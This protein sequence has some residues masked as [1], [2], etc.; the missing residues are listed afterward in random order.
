[1]HLAR[2][3][4]QQQRVQA[5]D[6]QALDVVRIAVLERLPDGVRQA[7]HR[8]AARPVEAGQ[9]LVRLQRVEAQVAGHAQ[10]V[11]AAHVFAPAQ[12]LADVA[13]GRG[14]RDLA[15]PP[16]RLDAGNHFPRIQQLQVQRRGDQR[17]VQ[18]GLPGPHRV[19][20]ASEVAQ[21]VGHEV[22]ERFQRLGTRQRPAEAV[23]APG[24]VGVALA[25]LGQHLLCDLVRREAQRRRHQPRALAAE[26]LA[27]VGVEVPLAAGGLVAVHQHAMALAHLAVEV[28]H[29]QL[30]PSLGVQG[31]RLT[32]AQEVTVLAELDRHAGLRRSG[33]QGL[34][35][36]PLARLGQHDALGR[37]LA[38]RGEQGV[39]Q[40]ALVVLQVGQRHAARAQRGR[41]VAHRAQ[42]DGDALLSRPHVRGFLAGL[43]HPRQIAHR[44]EAVEGTGV[45]VQLVAEDDDQMPDR[46]CGIAHRLSFEGLTCPRRARQASEQWRTSSQL[47]AQALRQVI[48]RPQTAQGLLGRKDLLPRCPLMGP[49]PACRATTGARGKGPVGS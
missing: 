48:G 20:P 13:F 10:P 37:P 8:R 29:A 14:Q 21:A 19:L 17:V 2:V 39:G 27:V 4:A 7:A 38:Q 30:A 45:F 23:Q 16:R 32:A 40:R 36:A 35:H 9:R 1:M 46:A 41:V 18:P 33:G 11:D 28:L 12:D 31:E 3:H 5:G 26:G 22:V 47:R 6:H 25:H 42:E 15:R 44:I 24:V 34:A 49:P 43:A